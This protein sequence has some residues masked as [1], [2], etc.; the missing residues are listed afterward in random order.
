MIDVN[1]LLKLVAEREK[2]KER[3]A[4]EARVAARV[5]V[6]EYFTSICASINEQLEARIEDGDY[7]GL[8]NNVICVRVSAPFVGSMLVSRRKSKGR[9][10]TYA[11]VSAMI[12]ALNEAY[13]RLRFRHAATAEISVFILPTL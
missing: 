9:R 4:E 8:N 5:L 6:R 12:E 13:P 7:V 3:E 10:P 11:E 1:N 2:E